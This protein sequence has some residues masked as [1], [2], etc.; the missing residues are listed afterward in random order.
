VLIEQPVEPGLTE[1]LAHLAGLKL[2]MGPVGANGR[3]HTTG[4]R[5]D[6]LGLPG[7]KADSHVADLVL[8]VHLSVAAKYVLEHVRLLEIVFLPTVCP[9]RKGAQ[10]ELNL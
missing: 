3:V 8:D 5:N 7:R 6:R 10:H 1:S 9:K 2:G 4:S